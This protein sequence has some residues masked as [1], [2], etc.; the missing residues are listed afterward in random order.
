[1][2]SL[3]NRR[4]T[5]SGLYYNVVRTFDECCWSKT[6]PSEFTPDK[7]LCK[8]LLVKRVEGN[9]CE[10]WSDDYT[11]VDNTSGV[12]KYSSDTCSLFQCPA[13]LE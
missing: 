4:A 7:S 1:M 3:K 8:S 6:N 13:D 12:L 10:V 2:F 11:C 5:Y 9:M